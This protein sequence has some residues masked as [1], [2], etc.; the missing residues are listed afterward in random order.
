M[1]CTLLA[2]VHRW[3]SSSHNEG[4]RK[5]GLCILGLGFRGKLTSSPHPC[6]FRFFCRR[7]CELRCKTV[8]GIIHRLLVD[9][10]SNPLIIIIVFMFSHRQTHRL[11][12][13]RSNRIKNPSTRSAPYVVRWWWKVRKRKTKERKSWTPNLEEEHGR[14]LSCGKV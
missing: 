14:I 8:S 4:G 2:L 3:V 10:P 7:N 12:G 6:S 5:N 1:L 13:R 9:V 11:I